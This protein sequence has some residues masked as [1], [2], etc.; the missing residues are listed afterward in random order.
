MMGS[1]CLLLSVFL[2]LISI[3]VSVSLKTQ[4]PN[5]K[6]SVFLS[7]KFILGHGHVQNKFYLNVDFP[8]GHIA[9]K[10]FDAEVID[11]AGNSIPLHETYLHHWVVMRYYGLLKNVS[12]DPESE[13]ELKSFIWVRNGGVCQETLGQYFGLGSET[14]HTRTSIPDPY[15][16]EVGNP[17]LIP[18]GYEER[19]LLNIHAI[20]TRGVEDRAG[21]TECRCDLYNVTKDGRGKPIRD[22][23]KGGLRCCY[24]GTKCKL[25][26]GFNGL[27]ARGLYLKYTVKWVEWDNSIVPVK[28]YIFDVTDT[29]ERIANST[30]TNERIGCQVE[31]D[32]QSCGSPKCGDDRKTSIV[33][34]H[35]GDV[36]YGVAHQHSGGVGST[37]FGQ[38]GRVIC[39]SMP[40][41][42]KGEEAGNEAGYI[43]GMSTCYPEPGSVK[44]KDGETLTLESRYSGATMHTGVM[45]LFYILVAEPTGNSLA[46][47]QGVQSVQQAKLNVYFLTFVLVGVAL[48]LVLGFAYVLKTKEE[49]QAYES[50]N[51][52]QPY[53]LDFHSNIHMMMAFKRWLLLPLLLLL[54]VQA[55]A[56]IYTKPQEAKVQ[57]SVFLSPKFILTPGLANNTVYL[58][59]DFP[60]GHIAVK[61]FIAELVDEDGNSVP[62]Y[63][64]YLHH[65]IVFRY[66]VREDDKNGSSIVV[67][68]ND[69]VCQD[70]AL[71]F[72]FGLGAESRKTRTWLPDPYGI[73]VGDPDKIPSGRDEKWALNVHAIDTRGV[74]DRFGC[75]ECR[76]DLFNVTKDSN[77]RP[78]RDNYLGGL[79][80]CYDGTRCKRNEGLKWL[81]AR[82]LHLKYTVKWVEWDQS[83]VPV[84]IYIF[85]VT[86]TGERRNSTSSQGLIGCQVEYDVLQSCSEPKCID[87]KKVSIVMP[88]GGNVI[89]GAAHLHRGGAGSTLY[90][91]DGRV[92]C[93]SVPIYG[94]GKEAGDEAGYVVGMSTCYPEPGS[95]KI[96]DGETLVLESTY[97]SATLHTGVMGLFYILVA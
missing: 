56:A 39:N 49:E 86:D 45:G 55:S 67:A 18:E 89:Y 28:I 27:G 50:I 79:S 6:T 36:I 8:K 3:H 31:Y 32:V 40:T 54:S 77:G 21:C 75:T 48:A 44:V 13:T 43:V 96:K 12:K 30:R 51:G 22:N 83:I 53:A 10:E 34:P 66:F 11:E 82:G 74:E 95:M 78:I 26:D 72:Y 41:Y 69:G 15:G 93:D 94:R 1:K 64:T 5:L 73:Q 85:D 29:G 84:K 58:D 97:N 62:L 57:S 33:I 91:Q 24:H 7:P 90:G 71:D 2:I 63:E 92:I 60:K 61:D 68:R 35:G 16:I 65:W 42:G 52:Q 37:L 59:I 23:Y 17:T 4:E 81:G 47:I 76:C 80:C 87:N 70:G 20:D 25:K 46:S 14:R 19:W 88:N 9:L 38:D